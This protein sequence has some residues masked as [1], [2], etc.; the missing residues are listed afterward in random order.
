MDVALGAIVF[1]SDV[2]RE[3]EAARAAGMQTRLAVRPGN[4]AVA[5]LVGHRVVSTLHD[6]C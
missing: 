5:P 2:T 3:L 6:V 4:P 1:V